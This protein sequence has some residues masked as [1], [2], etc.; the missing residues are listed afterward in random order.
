MVGIAHRPP[1]L[2]LSKA[3]RN[4]LGHLVLPLG[5]HTTSM[6]TGMPTIVG[7]S[8]TFVSVFMFVGGRMV[9]VLLYT[10]YAF[11][12]GRNKGNQPAVTQPPRAQT[13]TGYAKQITSQ[14]EPRSGSLCQ[15]NKEIDR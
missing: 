15:R 11:H 8:C 13:N 1:L 5:F 7:A 12:G 2:M 10:I 14:Q 9:G 6:M 3:S 4:G